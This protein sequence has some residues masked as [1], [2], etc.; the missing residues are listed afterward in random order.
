MK[1]KRNIIVLAITIALVLYLTLK[2]NFQIICDKILSTNPLIFLISIV[3]L[4]L[5]LLFKSMSL[6][7][8][9]REY[10]NDY[11][12]KKAFNLTI[13]AQFL[14]GI[15]PFQTGGQPFQIYLLKKDGLRIV[16]STNAMIK[17]FIAFQ[18]ALIIMGII[19][20]IINVKYNLISS[21]GL[22]GSLIFIG[23]VINIIVL[24][25]LIIFMTSKKTGI[26]IFNKIIDFAYKFIIIKK[27]KTTKESIK[28]SIEGFYKTGKQLQS[29]KNK[30]IKGTMYQLIS[31]TLLY[32]I[33]MIIF[34]SLGTSSVNLVETLVATSFVMLI[35]NFIPIPGATGGIEYGFLQF[36][37]CFV[38]GALL[39]SGMLL[40]RFVTYLLGLII[41]G[42]L[43]IFYKGKKE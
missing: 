2:D 1:N 34:I 42:L 13:I 11:S 38:S 30:L 16:D 21:S 29:N 6:N 9:I 26:T 43:L 41:G 25:I 12:I 40:W 17:D 39:S 35:G 31:L 23:F 8:F 32:S 20:I 3:A 14:N 24:L 37:G 19:S 15:T 4:I 7:T 18:F 28:D 27:L 5:S 22:V 36:F 33:P 10:N